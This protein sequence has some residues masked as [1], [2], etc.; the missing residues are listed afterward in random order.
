MK[1]L[2][3]RDLRQQWSR[4]EA[5]LETEGEI[6]ITRDGKPVARL[7]RFVEPRRLR[8]VRWV[9]EF[10]ARDRGAR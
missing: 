3:V 5:M 2:T 7:V 1:T 9:D 8:R 4:A 10:L 6:L